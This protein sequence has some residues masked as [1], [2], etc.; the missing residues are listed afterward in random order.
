MISDGAHLFQYLFGHLYVFFMS[1]LEKNLYSDL[2]IFKIQLFGGFFV[3]ELYEFV[4][5]LDINS[6]LDTWLQVYFPT[7]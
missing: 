3:T 2:P 6:L 7:H 4:V 5:C 1:S